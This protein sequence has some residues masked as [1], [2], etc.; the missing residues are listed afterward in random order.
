[1]KIFAK[2]I[3]KG[4]FLLFFSFTV[5]SLCILLIVSATRAERTA[6]V[7]KNSLYSGHQKAFSIIESEEED[8]WEDVLPNMEAEFEDFAIY[9]PVYDSELMMRGVYVNG[10]MEQ[11]PMLSGKYFDHSTSWT[12]QGTAVLGKNHRK[13][14]S[15]RG[16]KMY[17]RYRD[18][19][20]EVIGIMGTEAD[21]RINQMVLLDFKSSIRISGINNG[22][23]LDTK[24]KS[25]LYEIGESIYDHF[26][27]PASV[28]IGLEDPSEDIG[29]ASYLSGDAIMDTMYVMI[30]ISFSLST[31]LI[32]FIW[33]RFRA[34]LFHA[35]NLYGY[36]GHSVCLE[37]AK[38]FYAIT[39]A[40]FIMG[41]ILMYMISNIVTDVSM[42]LADICR[43]FGLTLGLGT[44]MLFFCYFVNYFIKIHKRYGL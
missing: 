25:L 5:I 4:N 39:G 21:S 42:I 22:Y 2:K 17:F 38:R 3:P 43:A 8:Q 37:I 13:D 30:L 40:G 12:D 31:I 18:T 19:D 14:V 41:I 36:E 29:I 11:P 34:P 1:M 44:I 35:W 23:I 33:F 24:K 10:D 32:T 6:E 27:Y 28:L 15:A 7:L 20:Y 26:Q 16:G 9:V